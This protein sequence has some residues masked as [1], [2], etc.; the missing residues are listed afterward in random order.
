MVGRTGSVTTAARITMRIERPEQ[1]RP[2]RARSIRSGG[3]GLSPSGRH[4][5]HQEAPPQGGGSFQ[6]GYVEAGTAVI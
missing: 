6:E 4:P 5:C 2:H 1:G 3:S